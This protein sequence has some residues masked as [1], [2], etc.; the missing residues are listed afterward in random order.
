MLHVKRSVLCLCLYLANEKSA[1]GKIILVR[2][3][4]K[5]SSH[6][7]QLSTSSSQCLLYKNQ[8]DPALTEQSVT[9]VAFFQWH[10]VAAGKQSVGSMEQRVGE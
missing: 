10:V 8:A 3:P 7:I 6:F 1:F 4:R 5:I 9:E 2:P